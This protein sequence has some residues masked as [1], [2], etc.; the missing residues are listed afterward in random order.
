MFS[1]FLLAAAPF[2]AALSP[3]PAVQPGPAVSV[4]AMRR[5]I[6]VLASDAF[7]G[8]K[9]GTAGEA[10]TIAYIAAQLQRLG[11]T[12][13]AGASGSP[14]SGSTVRYSSGATRAAVDAPIAEAIR[15]SPSRG[16]DLCISRAFIGTPAGVRVRP[17]PGPSGTGVHRR[18]TPSTRRS[19]KP[20]Y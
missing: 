8:R 17:T 1:P 3:A 10:K 16:T 19:T 9:P 6:D 15:A 5:H 14:L 11:L 2:L 18:P 7:E 4:E 13:A 12:P 20:R